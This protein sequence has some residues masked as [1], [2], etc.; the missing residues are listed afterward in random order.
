[1]P[2]ENL[3]D[4]DD[5][6][7]Q[8]KHAKTQAALQMAAMMGGAISEAEQQHLAALEAELKRRHLS[9]K[10]RGEDVFGTRSGS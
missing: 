3:L 1:M 7:L 8:T 5:E 10:G 2:T 6:Q 9:H 4:L